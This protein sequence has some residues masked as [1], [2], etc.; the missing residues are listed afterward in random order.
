MTND[1]G[2]FFFFAIAPINATEPWRPFVFFQ[3]PKHHQNRHNVLWRLPI[4]RLYPF[5]IGLHTLCLRCRWDCFRGAGWDGSWY[6]VAG[7][8]VCFSTLVTHCGKL[9]CTANCKHCT[10]ALISVVIVC[11]CIARPV[12]F[13]LSCV[14]CF[15]CYWV[16]RHIFCRQDAAVMHQLIHVW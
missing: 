1:D 15:E 16:W 8:I 7:W 14:L 9:Q 12:V 4:S 6:L 5:S 10:I 2:L 11:N 3:N 13:A